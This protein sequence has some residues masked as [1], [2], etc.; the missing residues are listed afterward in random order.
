MRHAQMPWLCVKDA[1]E[2]R[3]RQSGARRIL[4]WYGPHSCSR[5]QARLLRA[6]S[7]HGGRG[8]RSKRIGMLY[9]ITALSFLVTG[10]RKRAADPLR[11]L[12][13]PAPR[14]VKVRGHTRGRE[15]RPAVDCR[16]SFWPAG[17]RRLGRRASTSFT[18]IGQTVALL[19]SRVAWAT[20]SPPVVPL[21]ACTT[22]TGH[23]ARC[24]QR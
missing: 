13:R 8:R 10:L 19:S 14:Q 22:T 2:A 15:E 3:R 24:T 16:E 5:A 21:G 20:S 6:A 4:G 7:G 12:V 23:A 18:G 17:G 1:R 11:I 9:L